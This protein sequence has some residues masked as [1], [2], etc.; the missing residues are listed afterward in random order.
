MPTILEQS[1]PTWNLEPAVYRVGRR[2]AVV[3]L[4]AGFFGALAAPSSLAQVAGVCRLT[5]AS[6][7]GPFYFDPKLVRVD[8][9][10]RSIGTPLELAIQVVR[11][12]DCAT[13]EA[14]RV[15]V[16]HADGFGLYSG[17]AQ[18]RGTGTPPS[19][20]VG[21]E[22]LR[23]TQFTDRDGRVA[24]RTIYPSWYVGRTPHIHFKVFLDQNEVIASQMFFPENINNKVFAEAD[25]YRGLRQRRDTFNE[26]DTF[27]IGRT[28]GAFCEVEQVAG[29]Y[30][31][32]LVIG[33]VRA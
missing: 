25:P 17:Y 11:S 22:Y 30:R 31:A 5:P 29:V 15:D 19:S 33:V 21:E 9:T 10:E 26:N 13:L 24:F 7:E 8:I 12:D 27:L 1:Q 23:G 28:A 6:G 14:A 3:G 32:K 20:P 18:Q 4:T 16:W 2:D